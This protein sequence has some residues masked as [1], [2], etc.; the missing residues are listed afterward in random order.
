MFTAEKP[1]QLNVK[2]YGTDNECPNGKKKINGE[3]KIL[4]T[5]K[6]DTKEIGG[7]LNNDLMQYNEE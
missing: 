1:S 7:K 6:M 5:Y 3:T 2:F 4:P